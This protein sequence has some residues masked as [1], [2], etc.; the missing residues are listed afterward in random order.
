MQ[1]AQLEMR[2]KD[3]LDPTGK[4]TIA[5]VKAVPRG[6][7]E[8]GKDLAWPVGLI[9]A[10]GDGFDT[11][12]IEPKAKVEVTGSPAPAGP[13]DAYR[14]DADPAAP[15]KGGAAGGTGGGG[16]AA[17]TTVKLVDTIFAGSTAVPASEKIKQKI[18]QY[19]GD[20]E[21]QTVQSPEQLSYAKNQFKPV[22]PAKEPD[23]DLMQI[24]FETDTGSTPTFSLTRGFKLRH[25]ENQKEVWEA[26]Y[27][28]FDKYCTFKTKDENYNK[29]IFQKSGPY[30]EIEDEDRKKASANDMKLTHNIIDRF[31]KIYIQDTNKTEA[32]KITCDFAGKDAIGTMPRDSKPHVNSSKWDNCEEDPTKCNRN[33]H[34]LVFVER[35]ALSKTIAEFKEWYGQM[36]IR[37]ASIGNFA[38][39]QAERLMCHS[40]K[41]SD[42]MANE[43]CEP[44]DYLERQAYENQEAWIEEVEKLGQ[45][46][47]GIGGSNSIKGSAAWLSSI[48]PSA[49]GD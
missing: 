4:D 36:M 6:M 41:K 30:S 43:G 29:A 11:K 38:M 5:F 20:A 27:R 47:Q 44:L 33:K 40:L 2:M 15:L 48:S 31:F 39:L 49:G 19:I 26:W 25:L 32:T 14:N 37:A 7:K 3:V 13:V 18:K 12:P 8:T 9:V 42:E 28:I 1:A 23:G 35:I 46:A 24:Y 16:P 17:T 10:S 34:M 21:L 22:G 45:R